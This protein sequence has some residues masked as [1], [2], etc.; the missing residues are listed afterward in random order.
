MYSICIQVLF[1]TMKRN[2]S[3]YGSELYTAH[4]VLPTRLHTTAGLDNKKKMNTC[5]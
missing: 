2:L 4:G 1:K 5:I 3:V